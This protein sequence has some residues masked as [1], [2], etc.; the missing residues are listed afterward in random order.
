[1][2]SCPLVLL[3]LF[4]YSELRRWTHGNHTMLLE[5]TLQELTLQLHVQQRTGM[6]R[7]L[8]HH[9]TECMTIGSANIHALNSACVEMFSRRCEL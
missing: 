3:L 4:L 5:K 1:M 8:L 9:D 7:R 6:P 2:S